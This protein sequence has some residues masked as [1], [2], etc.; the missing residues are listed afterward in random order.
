MK[1][2]SFLIIIFLIMFST[3]P[4]YAQNRLIVFVSIIP[5]KYFLEQIGG[6][7][8]DVHIMVQPGANPATY[9]PKP[10]QISA[11]SRARLYFSIGVPFERAWMKRIAS[12]GPNM[13]IV[14][15]DQ[16]VEKREMDTFHSHHEGHHEVE[17]MHDHGH[18]LDPHI[19]LSPK[20]VKV[21]ISNML[22]ALIEADPENRSVYETNARIFTER[23]DRLDKSLVKIFSGSTNKRFMVFHPSWGYF[24][25]DY[26]L[27]QIPIEI[28]GKSPKP[29]QLGELIR[30]ARKNNIQVLFVQPQFS[31]KSAELI[32][33]EINGRV[34]AVDPLAENWEDNLRSVAESFREAAR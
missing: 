22:S 31:T 12:A 11:L 4:C 18:G 1:K 13:K 23:V 10:A 34:V 3:T 20:R 17:N 2:F 8:L 9:E 27:V 6:N 32:A 26:G 30:S 25:S 19:W 14:Q 33:G 5:Q 28:E 29:S 15:T 21:Q 16:G 7:L 24:A